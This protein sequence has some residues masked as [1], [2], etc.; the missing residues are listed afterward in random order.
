M[1]RRIDPREAAEYYLGHFRPDVNKYDRGRVFVIA[2]SRGMSGAAIL[3]ARAAMRAGGG[4]VYSVLPAGLLPVVAAALPEALKCPVGESGSAHFTAGDAKRLK[5]LA[6]RAD[7]VVLG[8]GLG[9]DESTLTLA[10]ELLADPEFAPEAMALVLDADGLYAFKERAAELKAAAA[11]RRGRIVITPHEGEA[12]ALLG[13]AAA[14]V[15]ARREECVRALA[16]L[17]DGGVAVLKGRETLTAHTGPRGTEVFVNTTGNPGLA[18]GGSGDVLAGMIAGLTASDRAREGNCQPLA[19][20]VNY[21][22]A[23]HGLAGDMLSARHGER[24]L[25]AADIIEGLGDIRNYAG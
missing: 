22:A 17:L 24:Y 14:E 2:G 25:T 12:A 4:L 19:N 3:S 5:E 10:R 23:L 16:E 7:A 1:M 15:K 18:T 9:R 13:I 11:L 21:G 8:P 6:R 20:I